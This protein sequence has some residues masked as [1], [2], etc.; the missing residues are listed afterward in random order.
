MRIGI[1]GAGLNSEYHIRF[2]RAHAAA[3][4][5]AVADADHARAQACA[6]QHGI[7][8]AFGSATDLLAQASPDIVHVVTPPRTHFPVVQEVIE[9]GRHVLVEKPLALNSAE[10]GVLYDLADRRGVQL[11]PMHNHLFDP[12]MRRADELIRSGAL[13]TVVNVESYYGL[14]TEIPAFRAYPRPNVLPWLYDLPGGVY[15]DFLPHPLYVLLEYTGRPRDVKLTQRSTGTLPQNMPDEIRVLVD[16]QHAL[17]TMT[18]SFA[19]RPHLHVVRVYGTRMMV[20][21]DINTMT[22]V[23]HPVSRLPKAA[24]KAT[25][26]LGE[27]WQLLR[28]TTSNVARF[29]TG[30]LKPYQGMCELIHRFYDAVQAGTRPPVS[31]ERALTVVSTMDA[32]FRQLAY[33]PL[34]HEPAPAVVVPRRPGTKKVLVTG[35]T[36]FLGRALVARLARDGHVVR[37]L[38]RKL[39]RIDQFRDIAEIFWGDV[40]DID[41]FDRAF[42]GCDFVVHLAAGTSGSED[43]CRTATIQG[44]ANLLQLARRHRPERVIYISSCSVYGVADCRRHAQLAEDAPLER[45]PERRGAYSASKQQAERQVL[46]YM[47]SGDVPFVVLRPGTIF[48][49]GGNL[50]TPMMGFSLGSLHAVIGT[51]GFVLPFVYVDNVADAIV[52]S[53]ITPQAAG[54]IFNVI[55]PGRV[56]KREYMNRVIRRVRPGAHVVYVP[57]ALLYAATW[58]QEVAFGLVKRN[59]PLTR[60]R[61]TSSQKPIVYDGARIRAT[62]GWTPP[63]SLDD[64]LAR[65]VALEGRAPDA[66]PEPGRELAGAGAA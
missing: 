15:Q 40:A 1:V 5:V 57:Y 45:F 60:Y 44:T 6:R 26:N 37:V 8:A 25:Y 56:T 31:R 27:S 36:G 21:I 41:S 39:A 65:L 53:L 51:G 55:D 42:A 43:D 52:Q 16:G 29:L 17:G 23:V 59:P 4:I 33:E 58:L 19:A 2:A 63:V 7:P 9:A 34:K 10:A 12:C 14:N 47:A 11:C 20:E 18:L 30:R 61:L 24:Q 28:S 22:T 64:A 35:A 38:A 13:G 32:I 46:D 48:G 54:Q 66:L 62:L 50:Y 3:E 49:P